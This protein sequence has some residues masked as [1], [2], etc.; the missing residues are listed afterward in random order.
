MGKARNALAA[1]AFLLIAVHFAAASEAHAAF[2][3]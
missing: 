3:T 2:M 1:R